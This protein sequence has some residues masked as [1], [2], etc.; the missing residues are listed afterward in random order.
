MN[1]AATVQSINHV[2]FML[3]ENHTFDNYFGMLNPYRVANG[4]NVG[5]DG[6]TYTVDGIDDKLNKISAEDDAGDIVQAV[7][8]DQHLR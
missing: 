5:D 4:Y 7:Q 6:V 1:P 2:I 3:Q 8:A